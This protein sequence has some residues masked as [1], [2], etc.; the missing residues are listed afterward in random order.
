[1]SSDYVQYGCGLFAPES[2]RNFDVSWTLRLQKLPLIGGAFKTDNF[3]KWPSNVEYGDIV[4]GLPIPAGS[5]K[6]IYS[7]HVMEHLTLNDFRIA[8]K[9]IHTHLQ[10]GG[11]FR[12]VMPD[13][14]YQAKRYVERDDADAAYEFMTSTH[15]GRI[16]HRK[17]PIGI[18]RRVF[19]SGRGH[20]W[21]WDYKATEKELAQV[22]FRNIRRAYYNDSDDEMFKAV[23]DEGRW[24]GGTVGIDCIK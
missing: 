11:T 12:F 13:L 6:A 17:D 5:A 16:H 19:G 10:D 21:L 22:G 24:E 15:L 23:E 2:W 9:N 18:L 8:L 14:Q 4:K 7:S 20:L 3:P 1:M